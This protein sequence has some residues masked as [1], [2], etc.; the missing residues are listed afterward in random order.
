MITLFE[1]LY[2]DA[3]NYKAFGSVALEG[4]LTEE[5]LEQVRARFLAND[6]LFITEQI[7]VPAL[8]PQLYQW[9]GGPTGDDHCWHEFAGIRVVHGGEV[10]A[11][12]RIVGSAQDFVKTLMAVGTWKEERSR[13]F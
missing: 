13:H 8:Y 2:R 3:G 4:A 1:Y 11:D 7:E 12:I 9:S 5:E 6:S 10:P